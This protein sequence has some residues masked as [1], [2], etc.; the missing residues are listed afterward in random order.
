MMPLDAYPWS[1]RYAWVQ[2]R[3][4]F[5]WQI[6][7]EILGELLSSKNTARSQRVMEALLKMVKPD[8][9]QLKRAAAE[10]PSVAADMRRRTP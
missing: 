9:K 10:P 1:P 3:F 4:G 8:I 5:S 7:P 6:V 2:D